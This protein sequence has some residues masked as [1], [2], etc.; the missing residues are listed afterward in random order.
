MKRSQINAALKEMEKMAK[1]QHFLLPPFCHF[2]PEDWQNKGE[3]FDEIRDNM[4]G[5]DITNYGLGDFESKGI[6]LITLRNGN[7]QNTKYNKP[8]AEKLLFLIEGQMAAMHFHWN[9]ME[10]IINRAVIFSLQFITQH[11]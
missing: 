11:L 2:T 3:V 10:D 5:W 6:S 4:L 1:K 8:Y 7:P 9:K